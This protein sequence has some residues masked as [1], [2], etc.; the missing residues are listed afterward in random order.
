MKRVILIHGNGGGTG[1]DHWQPVVK[2]ALEAAGIPCESPDFP[3]AT[4][5]RSEYWLPFLETLGADVE[6]V[7]VGHSSGAIAALRYAETHPLLG[8][9]LVGAYHTDLDLESEKLSGY[10]ETPFDWEAIRKNQSWIAIYA[11][12]DDPFIPI[13][14]PRY[15]AQQ[16]SAEYFE[17]T[18]R[19]HFMS[20]EFPELIA[21]LKQ[22]LTS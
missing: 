3:D 14:E 17:F 12:V 8:S 10:F 13:A 19:G 4:L 21:L 20:P 16:L 18:D 22:K 9:V 15:L 7:L 5:A 1:Q 2:A 6:T 11:S